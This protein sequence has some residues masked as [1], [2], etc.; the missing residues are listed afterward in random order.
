MPVGLLSGVGATVYNDT[1]VVQAL[2][3]FEAMN[4]ELR[5]LKEL[6][7]LFGC[8][9]TINDESISRMMEELVMAK[10]VWDTASAVLHQIEVLVATDGYIS[11]PWQH[12]I[13]VVI[14]RRNGI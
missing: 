14:Q 6:G 7:K 5:R 1:L 9:G 2:R 12:R 4:T 11:H 8:S 10:D 3:D 13:G